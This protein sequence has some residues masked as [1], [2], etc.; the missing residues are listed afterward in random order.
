MITNAYNPAFS[1]HAELFTKLFSRK[2]N[3]TKQAAELM[4]ILCRY[5][6]R[7]NH[8]I[9]LGCGA[10]HL[11]AALWRVGVQT[12]GVD[13][14]VRMI[15]LA[16]DYHGE[17][18]GI[19]WLLADFMVD[20]L[21]IRGDIVLLLYSLIQ[22]FESPLS[23]TRCLFQARALLDGSK[24]VLVECAN[25]PVVDRLYPV[26]KRFHSV[27]HHWKV[28]TWSNNLDQNLRERHMLV[29]PPRKGNLRPVEFIH[30]LYRTDQHHLNELLTRSGA[31]VFEWRNA[32]DFS[33]VF[34]P[35][36]SKGMLA[37]ASFG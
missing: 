13:R 36:S 35:N 24:I 17:A 3:P 28:T 25:D 26:G 23:Q 9:E 1:E 10:G 30:R 32:P 19:T 16:R 6:K 12:T 27:V 18:S 2:R 20:T 37:V 15:E 22:T 7:D 33:K 31:Q 5:G 14:S 29:T 8:I 11:C 21:S 34:N 4:S